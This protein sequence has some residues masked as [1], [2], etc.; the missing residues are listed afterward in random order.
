MT[1]SP[2]V[3]TRRATLDACRRVLREQVG[4]FREVKDELFIVNNF[5]VRPKGTG[6]AE[7]DWVWDPAEPGAMQPVREDFYLLYDVNATDDFYIVPSEF[8]RGA[9]EGAHYQWHLEGFDGDPEDGSAV[10]ERHLERNTMRRLR[11]WPV[12]HFKNAWDLLRRYDPTDLE[13]ISFSELSLDYDQSRAALLA[14]GYTA[15]SIGKCRRLMKDMKRHGIAH[16]IGLLDEHGRRVD[17]E[18][19]ARYSITVA[20]LHELLRESP[21]GRLPAYLTDPIPNPRT[22]V[23]VNRTHVILT[24][25]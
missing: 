3:E 11:K 4:R 12:R 20:Q 8:V 24:K 15:C 19:A 18:L 21:D 22:Y 13:A 2:M 14:K 25:R 1:S 23:A 10:N 16:E 17:E 6:T 5:T 7:Q 9:L